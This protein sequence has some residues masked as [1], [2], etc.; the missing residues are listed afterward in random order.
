MGNLHIN[1]Y[2]EIMNNSD[3]LMR[4]LAPIIRFAIAKGVRFPDMAELLKQSYV[5]V[6][7][8]IDLPGKNMT[9]SRMALLTGLQRRDL[10]ERIGEGAIAQ[11]K[12]NPVARVVAQWSAQGAGVLN[13]Q[14]FEVLVLGINKDMHPRTLLD[15]MLRLD[16][17]SE[18][19]DEYRLTHSGLITSADEQTLLAYFAANLGDHASASVENVLAAPKAGPHLD[20]AAHYNGLSAASAQELE[21]LA[22]DL[23]Q[24]ALEELN[25]KALE[26]QKSDGAA[27]PVR[28]R[29]GTYFYQTETGPE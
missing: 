9:T 25:T 15:E 10:K 20:R 7:N 28:V 17:V 4:V 21:K 2:W 16:V 23:S 27:G 26:L 11:I 22:R 29:F 24:K 14:E 6:A 3:A 12:P 19:D 5:G 1:C 8:R 18:Q 13:R